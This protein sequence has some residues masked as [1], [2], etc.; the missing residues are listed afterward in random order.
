M[1]CLRKCAKFY[2]FLT[3]KL[4]GILC[5]LSFIQQRYVEGKKYV[6][7]NLA[8]NIVGRGWQLGG[9]DWIRMPP[10]SLPAFLPYLPP[11][12]QV[13]R[14]TPLVLSPVGDPVGER[15]H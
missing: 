9:L 3:C 13:R 6:F 11:A 14:E 5:G 4:Q 2:D 10:S 8:L 15:S 1:K 7:D 12:K